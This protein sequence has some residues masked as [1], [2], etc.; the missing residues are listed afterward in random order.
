MHC[1]LSAC[2]MLALGERVTPV[3]SCQRCG[4]VAG[5]QENWV[6]PAVE[7]SRAWEIFGML[8]K[9]LLWNVS[10]S[11]SICMSRLCAIGFL[12]ICVVILYTVTTIGGYPLMMQPKTQSILWECT[13]ILKKA[14]WEDQCQ[15]EER[16]NKAL[17]GAWQMS[18]H[19]RWLQVVWSSRDA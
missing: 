1:T 10:L 18:S 2:F 4:C 14:P 15:V 12:C 9:D 19:Y 17:G 8:F 6:P 7:Y 11:E 16:R 5:S 3:C 13:T